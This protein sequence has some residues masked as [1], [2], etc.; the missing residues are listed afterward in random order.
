[1]QLIGGQKMYSS[2]M[3]T[4]YDSELDKPTLQY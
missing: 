3:V 1:M 2:Y 4:S